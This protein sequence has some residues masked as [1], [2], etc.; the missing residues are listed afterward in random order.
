MQTTDL[1]GCGKLFFLD[2]CDPLFD[3]HEWFEFL[4]QRNGC[5][6]AY[7]IVLHDITMLQQ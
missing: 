3:I 4:N 7:A 6:V 5:I 1:G 2:M